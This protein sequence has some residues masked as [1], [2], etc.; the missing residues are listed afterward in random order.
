VRPVVGVRA[1]QRRIEQARAHAARATPEATVTKLLARGERDV[2]A[3]MQE[4][5]ELEAR[6]ATYRAA[7]VGR[8]ALW[9]T[10][11]DAAQPAELRAAAATALRPRLED[12]ERARL[13][14]AA[15]ACASPKLRVAL[16]AASSENEE[17]LSKALEDVSADENHVARRLRGAA[18][19]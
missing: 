3:W 8:E 17:A 6:P 1:L 16:D 2:A 9:S 5:T 19:K 15:G 7:S 14:V 18:R 10:L 12:T 11:E 13:R 4:L